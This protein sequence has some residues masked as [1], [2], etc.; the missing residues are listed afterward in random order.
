MDGGYANGFIIMQDNQQ[1]S[2]NGTYNP[3]STSE[4]LIENLTPDGNLK[5]S[6]LEIRNPN[7]G[8]V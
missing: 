5:V 2:V 8:C 4:I 6:W 7:W 3:P 1:V